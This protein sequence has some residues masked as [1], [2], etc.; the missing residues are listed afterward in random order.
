MRNNNSYLK[1]F[2][3]TIILLI[4]VF[5]VPIPKKV[6]TACLLAMGYGDCK[7][8]SIWILG[9]PLWKII[10]HYLYPTPS[11]GGIFC[12]G[13]TGISCPNGY[14]CKYD[15]KYPDAGGVCVKKLFNIF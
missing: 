2:I 5:T 1:L 7:P 9:D 14:K 4:V 11:D 10:V 13:I 15:G 12:A 8:G 6:N 3:G